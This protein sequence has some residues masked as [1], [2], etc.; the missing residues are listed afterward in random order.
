MIGIKFNI[1]TS[2]LRQFKKAIGNK[3][4]RN[5]LKAATQPIKA[6]AEQEAQAVR[7]YGDLSKSFRIKV[8][9]YKK[10][11]VAIVGPKSS[12]QF[13]HGVYSRGKRKGQPRISQPSKYLHFLKGTK[14]AAFKMSMEQVLQKTA[15][16][17][18]AIMIR[19]IKAGIAKELAN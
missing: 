18:Q 16:Q 11:V 4:L 14:R 3:I 8:R 9:T 2:K 6:E 7:R 5:A 1:D 12:L 19:E 10:A 13:T 17:Y 15:A